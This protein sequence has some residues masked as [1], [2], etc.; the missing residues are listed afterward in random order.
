LLGGITQSKLQ[1]CFKGELH[2]FGNGGQDAQIRQKR[3]PVAKIEREQL[4]S[5]SREQ[6]GLREL[7]T[8]AHRQFS[9]PL[10]RRET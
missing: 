10:E 7:Q 4:S 3:E 9:P 8:D 2:L 5:S 6:A 1:F